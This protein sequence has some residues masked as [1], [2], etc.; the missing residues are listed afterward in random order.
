[1]R[2]ITRVALSLAALTLVLTL[3]VT[4]P[5]SDWLPQRLEA[6]YEVTAE[7]FGGAGVGETRWVWSRPSPNALVFESVTEPSGLY[8]LVKSDVIR[9]R[10]HIDV[11]TGEFRPRRYEY[12][13][14]GGKR[15]RIVEIDFDW[16][17]DRMTNTAKG[18]TRLMDIGPQTQDKLSYLLLV[19]RDL[20]GQPRELSYA[21][22]SGGK[23]ETY[24]LSV[25]GQESI[26]TPAGKFKT[27]R[28]QRL[29]QKKRST[30]LW[31]T[32]ALAYL[33]V[34]IAHQDRDGLIEVTL[35]SV[36]GLP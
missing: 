28:V 3:P 36:D 29:D 10:S 34:K 25:E 21:I 20:R 11:T 9:E 5:A 13:R 26:Q 12:R 30:T 7:A 15:D 8:S 6:R 24:R 19:M 22:A 27:I 18:Q 1:M 2:G 14:T 4:S 32:P 23:L 16:Q 35:T 17:A 31:F 33:P